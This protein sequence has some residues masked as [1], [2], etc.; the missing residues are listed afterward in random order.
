MG[1]LALHGEKNGFW[2]KMAGWISECLSSATFSILI[3]GSPFVFFS[4]SR[5][6]RQCDRLSPLLFVIVGEALSRMLHAASNSK[7][8]KGF[9]PSHG[10]EEISHLQFADDTLLFCDANETQICNIKAILLCFEAV[11]GLRVNFFKSEM[12]GVRVNEDR[13]AMFADLFGC[14]VGSLCLGLASKSLWQ[15]ILE[16]MEKKLSLWKANYLSLGGKI[17]LIKAAL[18]NLPTYFMSLFQCPME[19]IN[20]IRSTLR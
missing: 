18:T 9:R 11:S 2:C 10:A 7:L 13:L 17:T 1:V 8:M 4:A 6:L 5:G 15:P 19:V 3:N 12:I 16:R 20:K 14:K